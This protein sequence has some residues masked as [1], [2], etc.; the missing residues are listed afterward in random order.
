MFERVY[1]SQ[2]VFIDYFTFWAMINYFKSML[3]KTRE[4]NRKCTS[5]GPEKWTVVLEGSPGRTKLCTRTPSSP[6]IWPLALCDKRKNNEPVCVVWASIECFILCS[7]KF[8]L[9]SPVFSI[10]T[11]EITF[12]IQLSSYAYTIFKDPSRPNNKTFLLVG[13]N[14]ITITQF[15]VGL[16]RTSVEISSL[17]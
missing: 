17:L 14:G 9:S 10:S 4:Q 2:A 8:R 15:P 16:T 5:P 12:I 1:L 13:V 6:R 3:R 11:L 7:I